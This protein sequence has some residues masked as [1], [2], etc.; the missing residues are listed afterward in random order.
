[1]EMSN[2][3]QVVLFIASTV[4]ILLAACLVPIAFL[5]RYH[6]KRLAQTTERLESNVRVLVRDSRELVQNLNI[7]TKQASQQIEDVGKVAHIVHQWTA[8]ADHLANEVG[9]AI[10][11][12]VISVVQNVKR[13]R[14]GV[15]M[16]LR[17][18][19]HPGENKKIKMEE[20]NV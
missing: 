6:L 13:I 9:S 2:A 17:V 1:M 12:P 5:V 11:P 19:F 4:F 18:L 20:K 8:R 14:A 10:E 3:L 16:F 15:A 7:L